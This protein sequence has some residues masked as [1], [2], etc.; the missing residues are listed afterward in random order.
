MKSRLILAVTTIST[1]LMALSSGQNNVL[2]FFT[3]SEY[4]DPAIIKQFEK[5]FGAKVKTT[6]YE[7]NEDMLAK[8][9]A[10]GKG[11]YDL[12]VPSDY[13]IPVLIRK[14]LLQKFDAAK[15]PNLKNLDKQFSNTP[16]DPKNEYLAG[17]QW[18]TAGVLYRKDKLKRAPTTWATYYDS[19]QQPGSFMMMDDPRVTIGSALK[20][21]GKSLNSTDQ[22]SLRAAVTLLSDAK[23]RSKGLTQG[24]GGKAQV[25]SGNV[26]MAVVFNGDGVRAVNESKGKLGFV[27][28]KEGSMIALDFMTIP[29]GAPNPTLAHQ[30]I[31]YVLEAKIGAQLSN[32]TQYGT[33]NAAARAFISPSDL[34]NTGIYPDMA[35]MKNLEY[36]KDL[37]KDARLYDA[38]W[39]KFKAK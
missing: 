23:R 19:K 6:F 24:V 37:G 35:T 38:I 8:L 20:Y 2:N 12:I 14:N 15:I 10:G 7:S 3:W 22:E 28:P 9:E 33:P 26:T 1:S 16:V 25:E 5:Q 17:Y 27:V 39:T 30:F 4:I 36:I 13:I 11:Q 32:W 18:G 31:D 21:L 34:K 29:A